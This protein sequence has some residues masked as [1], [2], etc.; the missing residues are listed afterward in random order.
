M[1]RLY[2]LQ[3][4]ET[5]MYPAITL[6]RPDL[7]KAMLSYRIQGIGEAMKRAASGGYEGARWRKY[8]I[9]SE[10]VRASNV[11]RFPWESAFTGVE[12]TP[13][14][15]PLCRENQQHITGDIA[16]AARQLVSL[17]R[18]YDWLSTPQAATNYTGN[19]FIVEM[20]R[21]WASRPTFNTTKNLWEINGEVCVDSAVKAV[22]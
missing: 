22:E 8:V 11:R 4:Q 12:V 17:V 1:T 16:F 14:I 7:A 18:D 5:W 2:L 13:D 21:F 19:D 6:L 10:Q 15:C 20:A 3:K 9:I